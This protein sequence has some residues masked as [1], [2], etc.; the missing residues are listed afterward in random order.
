MRFEISGPLYG[1][2]ATG[3]NRIVLTLGPLLVVPLFVAHLEAEQYGLW[4][5]IVSVTSYFGLLNLGIAPVVIGIVAREHARGSL[6]AA[7]APFATALAI[8][9]VVA[10]VMWLAASL[11]LLLICH[12]RVRFAEG[13]CITL[14]ITIGF[15]LAALPAQLYLGAMRG[16][17]RVGEEQM[18]GTA[19]T[20][21]RYAGLAV[22]LIGGVKLVGIAIIHG[23]SGLVP[24]LLAWVRLRRLEPELRVS[25]FDYRAPIAAEILRPSLWFLVLQLAGL[26]V[27]SLGPIIIAAFIGPSAVP[28]YAVP[29]QLVLVLQALASVV[30]SA[31]TPY[32]AAAV[33]SGREEESRRLYVNL[34]TIS[35]AIASVGCLAVWI[36]GRTL[37]RVWAGDA[38]VPDVPTMITMGT[39][40]AIQCSLFPADALLVG[41]LRHR[42]YAL[43]SV[44]EGL[45]NLALSIWWV[46]IFGVLGVVLATVIARTTTNWWFL[47]ARAKAMLAVPMATLIA[48]L[49][50]AFIIPILTG[51]SIWTAAC[52]LLPDCPDRDLQV[53]AVVCLV[54]GIAAF[55]LNRRA[56]E[57]FR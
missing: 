55:A 46:Q 31:S 56:L 17:R 34:L 7:S 16:C 6:Q 43:V 24:G 21:L 41:A 48:I 26:L 15:F 39:L 18:L 33:A 20:V 52:A 44:L 13:V 54:A 29:L 28:A 27:W 37:L 11:A 19:S 45:I 36:G 3:L 50:R 9:L 38:V 12:G 10:S 49:I 4:I 35:M 2:F 53:A 32:L 42:R 57:A 51:L 5:T 8:Y 25:V 23:A 1:V 14:W 30:N 40:I 47:Q 22:G